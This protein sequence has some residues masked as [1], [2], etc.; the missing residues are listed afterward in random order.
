[1]RLLMWKYRFYVRVAVL[2][3]SKLT[4]VSVWSCM[5]VMIHMYTRSHVLILSVC[6]R[7]V[8]LQRSESIR[9]KQIYCTEVF[10]NEKTGW[11]WTKSCRFN[12]F[13][14]YFYIKMCF[15]LNC[16]GTFVVCGV[17]IHRKSQG[18]RKS[19]SKRSKLIG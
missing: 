15:S 12:R 8:L 2:S 16:K 1:M 7:Y 5:S 18:Q 6:R 9:I 13:L 10:T 4:F 3:V 17:F 14:L 19:A 11:F